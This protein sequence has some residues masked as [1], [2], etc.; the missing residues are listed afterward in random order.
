MPRRHLLIL[1]T[2]F[3][4]SLVVRWPLL[5]R[6]LSGHHELCSALVLIALDN[7]HHDGF[8]A[9]HGAPA[10]TFSGPADLV[11]PGYT[12]APG[13]RDGTLYY[14]SHPPLAFDLPHTLF[15]ITATEPSALGLQLFNI[16]FHLLTAIGLYLVVRE[17]QHEGPSPLFASVLY[18][19]MPAP[20][21]FHGNAYMSD[22]FV[23]NAWVWHVLVALRALK[24]ERP[25]SWRLAAWCAITLFITTTISWPGVWAGLALA[26]I[27]LWQ[28]RA[29]RDATR[30]RL[31]SAAVLGVGLALGYTA[32]RWLQVVDAN[33]L[34]AYFTGRYAERGTASI[35][36]AASIFGMLAL[37]YRISW[38][39]LLLPLALLL[40]RR[41][42]VAPG[43]SSLWLLVALTGLPVL[44]EM[45]FLLEYTGHDF[46]ALK[47]GLLLCGLGG[48]GLSALRA[49]WSWVALAATCV[50]GVLYFYRTNP[51]SQVDDAR[52]TWQMEQGRSIANE[53][54]SDEM[55][56]TLGF[57]PEPQVQWYAKRTL[58]RVDGVD[59]A[60]ALLESAGRTKGIVF[61]M[62]NDELKHER[63]RLP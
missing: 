23:Q 38:L 2:A 24:S 4:A 33:A 6:P 59:G 36:G 45:L 46:A 63:I 42:A 48:L 29:K 19:F 53:A 61:R 8:M 28:W 58:F 43:S 34:L 3:S 26:A 49:R 18:L 11:P 22:M 51:P 57:T 60:S 37:N 15:A 44:L 17:L 16:F 20:L 1:L 9:H 31:V 27:A 14:L 54:R 40:W 7:W 13:L 39:P 21:W 62:V 10:I 41:K 12:D 5:N 52:F 25:I 32:W 47:A 50:A 35:H 55:V 56:F 30:L